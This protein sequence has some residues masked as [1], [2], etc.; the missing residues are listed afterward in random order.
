V[1]A[2]ETTLVEG[3]L[4]ARM[5]KIALESDPRGA[6]VFEGRRRVATT[7]VSG[8]TM[9]AGPRRLRFELSGYRPA[10]HELLVNPDVPGSLRVSLTPLDDRPFLK[11]RRSWAYLTAGL[12]A[13][14]FTT[15]VVFS[16]LARSAES[17]IESRAREGTLDNDRQQ[18]LAASANAGALA[19]NVMYGVGAA[20]AVTS[21][22]LFAL[23]DGTAVPASVAIGPG[24]VIVSGRF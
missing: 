10:E 4:T 13:A 6:A 21:I 14:L 22:V 18:T 15:G 5:G 17:E 9:P 16:L 8:L 20:A 3:R 2:G 12:S 7:P 1:R 19:A 11:R 23:R 24:G